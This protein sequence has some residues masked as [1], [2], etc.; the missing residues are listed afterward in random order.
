MKLYLSH[1]L[2]I[3]ILFGSYHVNAKDSLVVLANQNDPYFPLAEE[4]AETETCPLI[5]SL[6]V[7]DDLNPQF[8]IHVASP[9]NLDKQNLLNFSQYFKDRNWYPALGII[10]GSSIENA[11][12][13]WL[14][15]DSVRAE[16][17]YAAT[18]NDK[19]SQIKGAWLFNLGTKP[20]KKETLDKTSLINTLNNADYFYWA[21]HV[22]WSGWFWNS[23]NKSKDTFL[24]PNDLPDLGPVVIHTPSCNSVLPARKG[25]IGLGF[26]DKGAAAYIGHL[27]TPAPNGS[28]FIGGFKNPAGIYTWKEFPLGIMTQIQNKNT[29]QFASNRPYLFMLGDPRIGLHLE[30]SYSIKTDTIRENIRTIEGS[31]DISGVLPVKIEEGSQYHY[32][33]I[34][35]LSTI[36]DNDFFCNTRLQSLNLGQDKYILFIHHGGEFEIELMEHVPPFREV[37]DMIQDALEY[38][39]IVL[40]VKQGSFSLILFS[41][42]LWIIVIRGIQKKNMSQ[43]TSHFI[44]GAIAASLY[45]L[46]ILFNQDKQDVSS[47]ITSYNSLQL[48]FG[49]LG[50]FATLTGGQILIWDS[51]KW[52]SKTFGWILCVLP[53]LLITGFYMLIITMF[54]FGIQ[55]QIPDGVPLWNYHPVIMLLI[56]LF[57]EIIICI[58]YYQINKRK[59]ITIEINLM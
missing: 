15:K 43:Y 52:I 12:N 18:D 10:T 55:K 41:I 33:K 36:S 3:T 9:E 47:Y 2:W 53:Q 4:I 42:L 29:M 49:F 28:V 11:R 20:C 56:V 17:I 32:L 59:H 54:N 25:N 16:N 27:F 40:G 39:W 8:I 38:A 24:G 22:A 37:T 13:L 14:R 58:I 7:M 44:F 46:Y 45:T 50:T 19:Q 35:G 21:R 5:E 48:C 30:K 6:D 26:V 51:K 23:E 1:I 31:S 34:K 57:L